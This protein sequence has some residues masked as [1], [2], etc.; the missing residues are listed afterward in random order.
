LKKKKAEEKEI[1]QKKGLQ[2]ARRENSRTVMGGKE[3]TTERRIYSL[4]KNRTGKYSCM[5]GGREK[6]GRP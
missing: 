3:E 2:N 1:S 5:L 6:G 4:A